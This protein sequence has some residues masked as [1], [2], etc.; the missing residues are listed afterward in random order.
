MS[1]LYETSQRIKKNIYHTLKFKNVLVREI[2]CPYLYVVM[3]F[4]NHDYKVAST[5]VSALSFFFLGLSMKL[6]QILAKTRHDVIADRILEEQIIRLSANL[7]IQTAY[8]KNR[9]CAILPILVFRLH[10]RRT[11]YAP[12]C[13]S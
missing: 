3:P 1:A 10:T 4:P 13:Q 8:Q 9:L 5:L 12:F 11:D 6:W 2:L 7:S